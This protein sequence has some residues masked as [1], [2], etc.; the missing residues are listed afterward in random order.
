MDDLDQPTVTTM[1]RP[2]PK[3]YQ[4]KGDIALSLA[5]HEGDFYGA[6]ALLDL[7]LA[8]DPMSHV[9]LVLSIAGGPELLDEREWF[10][11]HSKAVGFFRSVKINKVRDV[12]PTHI[13]QEGSLSRDWRPNNNMFRGVADYFTHFMKGS[14]A[15]Y[16]MEPDCCILKKD[17]WTQLTAQ[18]QMGHKPFMGVIRQANKLDGSAL[19]RHMNGSGLYPNPVVNYSQ[20]LY[21]ASMNQ[22]PEAAP[23]DVAGGATV[24][25]LCQPTKLICVDFS[26]NP[27]LNPEAVV[28]HGDKRNQM[29]FSMIEEFTG[30]SPA[31]PHFQETLSEDLKNMHERIDERIAASEAANADYEGRVGLAPFTMDTLQAIAKVD[32]APRVTPPTNAY[33]AYLR[34]LKAFGHDKAAWM[35]AVKSHKG[36]LAK[37]D[38]EKVGKK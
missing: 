18:Y 20:A 2:T 38:G 26:A 8:S 30:K 5:L 23:F 13:Q 34:A 14:G 28:W 29:K 24:V 3:N 31:R 7:I 25:P 19:P 27:I 36:D 11:F 35:R 9:D 6:K 15:F 12:R 21:A 1:L 4:L 32:E 33:E 17:W 16:Y 37:K 22:H 10:E